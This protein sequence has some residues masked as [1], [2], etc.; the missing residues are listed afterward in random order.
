MTTVKIKNV[1]TRTY[2]HLNYICKPEQIMEIPQEIAD[3]WFKGGEIVK[4]AAPEDAE[5]LKAENEVLKARLAQ[6]AKA[7]KT[8]APKGDKA[9]KASKTQA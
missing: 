4:Y 3:I 5:K 7:S 8:Q 6:A 1:S 9:A 2:M